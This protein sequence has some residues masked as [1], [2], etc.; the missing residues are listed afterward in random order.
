[1]LQWI[2][3]FVQDEGA[4]IFVDGNI[5][6]GK[7]RFCT[8]LAH[9]CEGARTVVHYQEIG[10]EGDTLSTFLDNP[11][12]LS[13]QFQAHMLGMCV[14]REMMERVY[15]SVSSR[16]DPRLVIVDRSVTGN[17]VFGLANHL[18]TAGIDKTQ[19]GLYKVNWLKAM[20]PAHGIPF[21]HGDLSVYLHVNSAV[22][23]VRCA[24]RDRLGED[25]YPEGYFQQLECMAMLAVLANT[26]LPAPHAQLV[27]DW[28]NDVPEEEDPS[29]A[30]HT[31]MNAYMASDRAAPP[32]QVTLR[33]TPPVDPSVYTSVTDMRATKSEH[34]F[35]S[36]ENT[37]MLFKKVVCNKTVLVGADGTSVQVDS[38]FKPIHACVIVPQCL[39]TTPFDGLFTLYIHD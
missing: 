1:M 34:K 33:R 4:S 36:Y 21:G 24:R 23:V 35:F 5:S 26:S 27:L 7:G 31:I 28:N 17:G 18:F 30:F 16:E 25:K 37:C 19:F 3:D 12:A 2:D 38:P 14:A 6:A 8:S 15:A 22:S 20:T 39:T 32:C 29:V 10:H 11:V 9:S 13:P